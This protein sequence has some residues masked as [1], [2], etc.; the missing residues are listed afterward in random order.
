MAFKE[1]EDSLDEDMEDEDSE[2][3]EED[4]DLTGVRKLRS[5][6]TLLQSYLKKCRTSHASEFFLHL[7][8][9]G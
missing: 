9:R 6:K 2:E 4:V 3:E 5:L 8:A 7:L 1:E